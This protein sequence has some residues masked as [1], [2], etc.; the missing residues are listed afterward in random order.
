VPCTYF[1]PD[2]HLLHSRYEEIEVI[3]KAGQGAFGSVYVA[4]WK[5]GQ[6]QRNRQCRGK[7]VVYVESQ[8]QG[9]S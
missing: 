1:I 4:M 7:Y 9:H 5:V 2:P 6:G 3:A 8:C